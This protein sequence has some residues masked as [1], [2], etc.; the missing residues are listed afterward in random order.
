MRRVILFVLS[1]PLECLAVTACGSSALPPTELVNA[2]E[3]ISRAQSGPAY[4]LDPAQVHDAQVAL[5]RAERAYNE[6]PSAPEIH[7]LAIVAHLKAMTAEAQAQGAQAE[8]AKAVAIR[9]RDMLK[10]AARQADLGAAQKA[11]ATVEK[12][13]EELEA[14]LEKRAELAKRIREAI[15]PI[16]KFASIKDSDRGL[17]VTLYSDMLFKGN[18]S[19]LTPQGKTK[20]DLVTKALKN[21][22]CKLSVE[23]HTDSLAG[24][25][26]T[27]LSERR[28]DAVKSY[29]V[30]KGLPPE[31]VSSVGF[32]A[33]RPLGDN[34]SLEGR[35]ENR[36]IEII[37]Q[38]K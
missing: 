19:K 32:G 21:E 33:T 13:R 34:S 35:A 25:G 2:R 23:G 29:L 5:A 31:T 27:D 24:Y 8:Q 17:V 1:L 37:V 18:D 20:L 11:Q 38:P 14:T 12:T 28:A 6:D 4:Q 7:D 3:A 30:S 36:R 15:V 10:E 9:E 16:E 26:N 22:D